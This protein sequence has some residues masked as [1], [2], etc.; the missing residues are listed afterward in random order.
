MRYELKFYRAIFISVAFFE[1]LWGFYMESFSYY[2]VNPNDG[3][4]IRSILSA[5]CLIGVYFTYN[6][7]THKY[8]SGLLVLFSYSIAFQQLWYSYLNHDSYRL[9]FAA[10]PPIIL[11]ILFLPNLFH[12]FNLTIL[13]NLLGLLI[14][15]E[16]LFFSLNLFTYTFNV[17]LFKFFYIKIVE[18][19]KV[20]KNKE[21][22]SLQINSLN[23]FING[24][25]HEVNNR[26]T[27]ISL[28]VNLLKTKLNNIDDTNI[29]KLLV[30][31]E[32][33]TEDFNNLM[34]K[35]SEDTGNREKNKIKL[36]NKE[37]KNI[38]KEIFL[39]Y[40]DIDFHLD[41]SY[42]TKEE[43]NFLNKEMD[44]QDYKNMI[45]QIVKNSIESFDFKKKH[46][47][48]IIHLIKKDNFI[49]E[50]Y[51]NGTPFEE[52]IIKNNY[53]FEPFSSTKDVSTNK[54]LG[55]NIALKI[56]YSYNGDI[57]VDRSLKKISIELPLKN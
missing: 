44:I 23:K 19:I 45:E 31:L 16:N 36:S 10:F 40:D 33:E 14:P 30:N 21:M 32:N 56:A 38:Y 50:I 18:Q 24:L 5:I 35:L 27:K 54:G 22:S 34:Q 1:L 46:S 13:L 6:P 20:L 3:I 2:R 4:L 8:L 49:I 48:Y 52:E 12:L 42:L 57:L 9:L 7:K 25:S 53:L 17:M 55:L 37:L 15:Q 43:E 29:K 28:I 11:T 39:E 26:N 51:D 47:I 41:I